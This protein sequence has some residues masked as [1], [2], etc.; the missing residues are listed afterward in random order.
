MREFVYRDLTDKRYNIPNESDREE[1]YLDSKS[2]HTM[3]ID[4][5]VK[6]HKAKVRNTRR[7]EVPRLGLQLLPVHKAMII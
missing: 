2:L 3:P 7:P 1:D 6:Y 4:D 5:L